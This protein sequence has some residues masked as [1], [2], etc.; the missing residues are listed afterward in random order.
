[1][2]PV[3]ADVVPVLGGGA[4]LGPLW[5]LQFESLLGDEPLQN[6]DAGFIFL[7]QIGGLCIFIKSAFL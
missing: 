5:K 3:M 2:G 4:L 1:M 7:D 6:S